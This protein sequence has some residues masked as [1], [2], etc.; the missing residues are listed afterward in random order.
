M[1]I[2]F[3]LLLVCLIAAGCN[4]PERS[5]NKAIDSDSSTVT[6]D[7]SLKDS[8]SIESLKPT[9]VLN[10]SLNAVCAFIAG[11]LPANNT[12]IDASLLKDKAW[13]NYH[14]NSNYRWH[15]YDSTRLSVIKNWR[16]KELDALKPKTYN[17]F[18]PFSGPDFLNAQ[19]FFPEADTMVLI[20]LEPAGTLPGIEQIKKDTI[21]NYFNK[22]NQSLYSILNFS[23]FRTI[24]MEKD[25]SNSDLNG[26]TQILVLFMKRT[27]YDIANVQPVTI[28]S[29]GKEKIVPVNSKG[30]KIT[31]VDSSNNAHTL[32]YFSQNIVDG[33][34][35]YNKGFRKFI[36]NLGNKVSY[37]KSASYLMHKNHF[38]IVRNII[39]QQSDLVLQDDSGIPYNF[40][41][42]SDR[43]N[44]QLFGEYEKPIDLFGRL[45]QDDLKKAYDSLT[46]KPL[47]FGTGYRYKKSESNLLLAKR[48]K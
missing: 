40:F 29:S 7:S 34:L 41:S 36:T 5:G 23:F 35:L 22:I 31:Y 37:I 24:A 13:L 16:A 26:T 20:G 39:L 33:S 42:G 9:V 44:V 30:V 19:A 8:V 18:Y 2:V 14:H 28:D 46:V 10:D 48:K 27:G 1:K 43:F 32:Y 15:L 45:Y 25:F 11:M 38:S 21:S 47:S 6:N 12:T 4:N 3:Y 17:L